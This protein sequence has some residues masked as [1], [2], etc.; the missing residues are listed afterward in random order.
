MHVPGIY[1]GVERF[2]LYVRYSDAASSKSFTIPMQVCPGHGGM[3]H[4][5]LL[6]C[7]PGL[8]R[9]RRHRLTKQ[10]PLSTIRSASGILE[11]GCDVPPLDTILW[12]RTMIGWKRQHRPRNERGKTLNTAAQSGESLSP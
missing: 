1:P 3:P 10:R 6:V 11:I 12:M 5:N 2:G 4:P 9:A 7:P 8:L